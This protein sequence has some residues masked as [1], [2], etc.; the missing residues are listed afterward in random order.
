M[1]QPWSKPEQP[2]DSNVAMD[3]VFQGEHHP[4]RLGDFPW[5]CFTTGGTPYLVDIS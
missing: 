2:M 1:V 3:N 4:P 5:V